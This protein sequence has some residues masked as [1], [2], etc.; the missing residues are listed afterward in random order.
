[1]ES[2][3]GSM[4]MLRSTLGA[5]DA[6]AFV[7]VVF[8]AGSLA[9]WHMDAIV[10]PP[11]APAGWQPL[12]W[13]YEPVT[14]AAAQVTS[15][16]LLAALDPDDTHVLPLGRYDLT[17]PSLSDQFMWQRRPSRAR[18]DSVVL[19]WPTWICALREPEQPEQ[20]SAAA[21]P[22]LPD[23]GR[24]PILHELR[25]RVPG[26]LLRRILPL[27]GRAG[28]IRVRDRARG[29]GNGLAGARCDYGD[30]P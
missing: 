18:F 30:L 11:S 19:P 24:L 12:V 28:A 2:G 14:F 13:E 29:G 6:Q 20:L 16:A 26:F 1:M 27:A 7:R 21:P 17:L 5:V 4:E 10:A 9:V 25:G 8:Q 22:G 3:Q 23:R 15:K